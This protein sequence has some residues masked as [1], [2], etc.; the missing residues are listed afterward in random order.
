MSITT[1][2]IIHYEISQEECRGMTRWFVYYIN[3]GVKEM[4]CTDCT[5]YE[6]LRIAWLLNI[7]G[8]GNEDGSAPY[9]VQRLDKGID[10]TEL[11]QRQK[12]A[13]EGA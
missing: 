10:L 13:M 5:Y 8:M 11:R 2:D 1:E 9:A 3:D 6:A 7:Y 12:A 4:I